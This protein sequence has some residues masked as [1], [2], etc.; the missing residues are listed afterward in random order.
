MLL[1]ARTIKMP[2]QSSRSSKQMA[3]GDFWQMPVARDKIQPLNVVSEPQKPI[4]NESKSRGLGG[5]KPEAIPINKHP[6]RLAS[7]SI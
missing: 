4:P 1:P 2:Q 5:F 3:E 7:G 6:S